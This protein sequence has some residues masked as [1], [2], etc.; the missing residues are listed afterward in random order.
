MRRLDPRTSGMSRP[1]E[2]PRRGCQGSEE[3]TWDEE[4]A[5]KGTEGKEFLQTMRRGSHTPYPVG[6]RIASLIPPAHIASLVPDVVV[7]AARR[8]RR[9]RRR[10]RRRRK[11]GG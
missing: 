10:R 4:C 2:D 1:G 8:R 5:G 9:K 3:G 6:R 11:R 7:L